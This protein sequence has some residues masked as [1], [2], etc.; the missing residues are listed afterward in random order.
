MRRAGV[1][2][3]YRAAAAILIMIA[4][5]FTTHGFKSANTELRRQHVYTHMHTLYA[6]IF[7]HTHIGGM[8]VI[9]FSL[10]NI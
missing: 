1:H 2:S 9:E 3:V 7:I 10:R 5:S 6:D 4:G 8:Q